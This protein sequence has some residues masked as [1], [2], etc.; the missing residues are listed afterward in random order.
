MTVWKC[1]AD[2]VFRFSRATKHRKIVARDASLYGVTNSIVCTAD[3]PD[4]VKN[5]IAV[6][7]VCLAY[8]A[9]RQLA[10]DSALCGEHTE[11]LSDIAGEK[12]GLLHRGKMAALRHRGPAHNV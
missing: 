11:E 9:I 2:V 10:A 3:L 12:F 5:P 7:A 6:N 8:A 4:R 1:P